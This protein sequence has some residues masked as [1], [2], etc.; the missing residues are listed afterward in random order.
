MVTGGLMP[1]PEP[2]RFL[3]GVPWLGLLQPEQRERVL[4]SASC[5]AYAK[6][7]FVARRGDAVSSWL[8]VAE[9]WL[10]AAGGP[11]TGSAVMFTGIGP[12][13]WVGEGSV[14]KRE[15]R[16]YDVI[17]MRPSLVVH[18]PSA[19]F[20]WLL[21]SSLAFAR[22]VI[23]HLNARLG[24]YISMFED[25]RARNPE[26]RLA[27]GIVG[28]FDPMLS[29]GVGPLLSLSQTEIGGLIGLSRQRTNTAMK[30]LQALGL[31][32]PEHG[33]VRVCNLPGLRAYAEQG[34]GR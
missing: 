9:G 14:I 32:T 10:K 2:V 26:L 4:R 19:T 8:G 33:A 5:R 30:R 23:D 29:P 15:P 31:L 21:G 18:V 7:E 6:D 27:R 34:P 3:S 22:F 28:F 12:G 1:S 16:R 13:G 11:A 17:A 25:Q 20:E 24:Q